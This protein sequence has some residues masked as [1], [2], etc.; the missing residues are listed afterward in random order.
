MIILSVRAY[1]NK[2]IGSLRVIFV[3]VFLFIATYIIYL[4][5][6]FE[7]YGL[8]SGLIGNFVHVLQVITIDAYI[9]EF[10][11]VIRKGLLL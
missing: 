7:T 4:P 10:Y 6:Y 3:L 8:L 11:N 5:V 2:N 9:M 1:L